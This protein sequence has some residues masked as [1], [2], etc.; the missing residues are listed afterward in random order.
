ML[1]LALIPAVFL[2]LLALSSPSGHTPPA[3]AAT[4]D[5]EYR[6]TITN[7]STAQPLSAPLL[8]THSPMYGLITPGTTASASLRKLAEE[9]VNDD[10]AQELRGNSEVHDV[11]AGTLPLRRLG[12]AGPE[13]SS[14]SYV[15]T[16]HA[17]A[18]DV[19]SL[20]A[21]LI[22]TNDGFTAAINL[23]LPDLNE[24]VILRP[25]IFDA[26]SEL[27]TEKSADLPDSCGVMGAQTLSEEDG[28]GR[29]A[30]ADPISLH[31]GLNL[32]GDLTAAS[33]WSGPVMQI[34]IER[35]GPGGQLVGQAIPPKTPYDEVE[36]PAPLPAASSAANSGT[37]TD[38]AEAPE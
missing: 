23:P 19:L 4:A 17:G 25:F 26:G 27:N 37:S 11:V 9:G 34:A 3:Q 31:P 15:F 12:G 10:L 5:A 2:S 8:V 22:C 29:V 21:M 28:N 18:G 33:A 20:A 24:P 13:E 14:S 6:I 16:I 1:R 35:I 32:K 7:I 30:T 36:P 38:S